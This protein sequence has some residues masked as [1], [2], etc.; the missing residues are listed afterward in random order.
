MI[1]KIGI[2]LG[3]KYEPLS[4][5]PV[6]KI[7]EWGPWGARRKPLAFSSDLTIYA[8]AYEKLGV[9]ESP[10]EGGSKFRGV[11][12]IYEALILHP[13]ILISPV[14]FSYRW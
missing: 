10:R 2:F 8:L 7:C 5:P 6:I 13:L 12:E 11:S 1:K 14:G 3:I 4:D 9:F